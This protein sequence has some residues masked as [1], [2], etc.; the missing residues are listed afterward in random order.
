MSQQVMSQVCNYGL[1]MGLSYNA[2]LTNHGKEKSAYPS[3]YIPNIMFCS[4][5]LLLD[6]VAFGS[7]SAAGTCAQSFASNLQSLGI[8]R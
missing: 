8:C 5:L 4:M 1:T 6:I 3:G 2:I 7:C